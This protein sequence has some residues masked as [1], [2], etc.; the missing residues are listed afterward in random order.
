MDRVKERRVTDGS[1][2]DTWGEWEVGN[3]EREVVLIRGW[4][5]RATGSPEVGR[6]SGP[7]LQT[8][9]LRCGGFGGKTSVRCMI[10]RAAGC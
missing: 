9:H 10:L 8:F 4:W 6:Q 3:H 1:E 7:L 2:V 5:G